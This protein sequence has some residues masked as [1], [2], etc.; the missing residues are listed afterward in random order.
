MRSWRQEVDQ[1]D[2][3]DTALRGDL[4]G[5]QLLASQ[6]AKS[7]LAPRDDLAEADLPGLGVALEP[8]I[9][10]SKKRFF[11]KGCRN[12]N[13]DKNKNTEL[14]TRDCPAQQAVKLASR[15]RAE[16]YSLHRELQY[17]IGLPRR[18]EIGSLLSSRR[19]LTRIELGT[20]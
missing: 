18:L 14:Q 1:L 10:V 16:D 17:T 7:D 19:A 9:S 4:S 3:L 8:S 15:C 2:E 20:P 12:D 11:Q 13:K 6:S 5:A